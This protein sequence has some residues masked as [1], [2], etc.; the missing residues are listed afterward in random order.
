[1]STTI[2]R[3][4]LVAVAALGLSLVSV[5]PSNAAINQDTLT[6]SAATAAQ[7]TAETFTATSAVATLSFLGATGDSASVTAALVSGPAGNTAL[8][9]LRLTETASATINEASPAAGTVTGPNTAVRVG[10]GAGTAVTT[11]KFAVY[12][13]TSAT[14][15]PAVAGTYVVRVTPATLGASGS[16]LGATAQTL[17]I[18]VTTAAAQDK[19]VDVTKSK[20]II[21]AGETN[22]AT[23]DAT[24]TGPKEVSTTAAAGT[25]VVTLNNAAGSPV[26]DS[27]T[28]QIASGPGT[29]GSGAM[30]GA[31]DNGSSATGRALTIKNGDVVGVFPDGASGVSTI[32]IRTAAGVLIATETVTFFGA[33]AS[34]VATVATSVIG[35]GA[36]G[37]GAVTA[38]AKDA[39]GTTITAPKLYITSGTT[40]I[41]SES[42]AEKTG[43]AGVVKFD[44]TGVKA[45]TANLTVTNGKDAASSTVSAVAV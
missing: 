44:L 7:T 28:A 26:V 42:Y 8:P 21:N 40:T 43:S 15:A 39:A 41:I 6:L 11:A 2:K 37:T 20:S 16:L 3:I 9:Y 38:V 22:T 32:E 10:A 30:A 25:I 12:L 29:L 1:M 27:F 19:T 14:A 5:A 24:V 4:A 23:S 31:A 36:G 34:I 18:T 13:G 35:V 33:V 17:T 45:G